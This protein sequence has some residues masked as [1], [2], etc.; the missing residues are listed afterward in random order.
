M[1]DDTGPG[2]RRRAASPPDAVRAPHLCWPGKGQADAIV[3][4]LLATPPALSV[5]ATHPAADGGG[6]A[7]PGRLIQGDNLPV[8]AALH[9]ELAGQIDLVVTD[10]PFGTGDAFR[11][12]PR[13][14]VDDEGGL[15]YRDRWDGG[16]AGY[17]AM[18]HPRLL[19]IRELLSP[20]GSLVLHCDWRLAPALALLCDEVFGPGERGGRRGA[21]GF[22]GEI[23]WTYGLGGSSRRAYPRKHD[24]LLWYSKGDDW[25][26][27]P[28]LVP[29]TSQRLRGQLKKCPDVWTDIPSLNNMAR[30]RTG[31][32]T[33]KP[34]ALLERIVAAHSRPGDLVA[35]FF[36][37]SGTTLVAAARLGRRWLGCDA[38]GRAVSVAR[39]RLLALPDRPTITELVLAGD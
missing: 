18:I 3:D 33:Q 29:A 25:T 8:M 2:T 30:E 27:T 39:R 38:S 22:R 13:G 11:H 28:P 24:T 26:F 15:A 6:D 35:D 32:P 12:R 7:P 1:R 17:L 34:L 36:C 14:T 16:P 5:R 31:Y 4:R 37:G 23:V 19:L 10:P 21:P 20:A 9:R